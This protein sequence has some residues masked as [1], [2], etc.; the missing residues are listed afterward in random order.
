MG[1]TLY[2]VIVLAMAS[3]NFLFH[4]VEAVP[5]Q[6]PSVSSSEQLIRR[7]VNVAANINNQQQNTVGVL[8]RGVIPIPSLGSARN[9]VSNN[10]AGAAA[11]AVASSSPVVAGRALLTTG[12]SPGGGVRQNSL[13]SAAGVG[14]PPDF[15][16]DCMDYWKCVMRSVHFEQRLLIDDIYR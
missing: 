16:C 3:V 6:A 7:Q 2:L 14:P 9:V 13:S 1:K 4:A 10:N 5:T 11:A 15:S 8:R 12:S